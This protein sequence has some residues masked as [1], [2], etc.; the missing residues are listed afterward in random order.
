MNAPVDVIGFQTHLDLEKNYDW[1]G[2]ANNIKRYRLLGY[3]VNIPEVD[4]GD[5]AKNWT[6]EKAELQKLQ[7][8]RLVTAAI[9]GGASDFQTW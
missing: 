1:E 4:I 8:Y 3:E 7:Y 6:E 9:R 5:L 2:Y